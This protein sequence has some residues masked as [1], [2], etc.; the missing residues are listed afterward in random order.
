VLL[1]LACI[2]T[3][4]PPPG[5]VP[6]RIAGLGEAPEG[7]AGA[8]VVRSR[9]E[10]CPTPC[11]HQGELYPKDS[12]EALQ[13]RDARCAFH[14]LPGDRYGSWVIEAHVPLDGPLAC[15]TEHGEWLILDT[16][17]SRSTPGVI[18]SFG[19]GRLSLDLSEEPPAT[20]SEA[21]VAGDDSPL[22][23]GP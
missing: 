7:C 1:L 11:E 19:N 6:E 18:S 15:I 3:S 14:Q 21:C 8:W 17:E 16:G 4:P 2:K 23:Q 10:V 9:T 13:R 20:W 5:L 22:L 12:D